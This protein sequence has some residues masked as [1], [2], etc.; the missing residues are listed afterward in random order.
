MPEQPVDMAQLRIRSIRRIRERHL[1]SKVTINTQGI[2]EWTVPATTT[3]T[4]DAYGANGGGGSGYLGGLGAR[5]KGDFD[6][7]PV[8]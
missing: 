3:Y 8:T 1:E 6:L 5:I 2:Q 7:Q 4:I